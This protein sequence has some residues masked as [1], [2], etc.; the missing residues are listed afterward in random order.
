[1]TVKQA[2]A[3]RGCNGKIAAMMYTR[4]LRHWTVF[5]AVMAL[6]LNAAIPML[7]SAAA[8]RQGKTV[9]QICHVYGVSIV[10]PTP[11]HEHHGSDADA[12]PP[13]D[14]SSDGELPALAAH[15]D[16]CALTALAA[17]APFDGVPVGWPAGDARIQPAPGLAFAS[18]GD[19]CAAWAARLWHGPPAMA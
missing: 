6:W 8:Q 4:R 3:A 1:M 10:A 14:P 13:A 11:A 7:A 19:A 17:L 15:D 18:I 2:A 9:A 12:A 16:H 5:V